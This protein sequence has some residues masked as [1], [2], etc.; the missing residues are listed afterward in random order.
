MRTLLAAGAGMLPALIAN[1]R[2]LQPDAVI[3]DS[4]TVWGKQVGQA[5]GV[6]VIS[7]CSIF[8]ICARNFHALPRGSGMFAQMARGAPTLARSALAYQ[9][10]ARDIRRRFGVPSPG[11]L[12]F[13]ANPGDITLVFTS[14]DFTAGANAFD[15]SFK[16]VGASLEPRDDAGD[17]PLHL[18]EG[19]RVLYVSLG[20]LFN[21][22]LQFFRDCIEAFR[23]STWRVVMS[24]GGT[25][26][27]ADLGELP[28]NLIVRPHVPQLEVLSRASV[29][30][31]HGGMNSTSEAL[32]HGVPLVVVPQ[33]G[34]QVFVAQRI[35]ELGAGVVLRPERVTPAA[36]R[37]SVERVTGDAAFDQAAA[38]LGASLR[39][40]G[41]PAAA[42]EVMRY[43][44]SSAL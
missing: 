20:T 37:A 41:A 32:W 13:F 25:V 43:V 21:K 15:A 22:Q 30:I 2:A 4:M 18:L 9:R 10:L 1:A 29:F 19:E 16:F 31:T 42:D 34:D 17:F 8:P 44:A 27:P 7:S 5:L 11:M 6:P 26:Q 35:A 39:A 40:G 36:L 33:V 24:I 23:G 28:P 14:R 12:D 3:Y 38:R